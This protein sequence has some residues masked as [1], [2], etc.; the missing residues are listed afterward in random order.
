MK[1]FSN[2]RS[3]LQSQRIFTQYQ[4]ARGFKRPKDPSNILIRL[5][6]QGHSTILNRLL[7]GLGRQLSGL[8]IEQ[9]S[10]II[11]LSQ[12]RGITIRI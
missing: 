2:L 6:A 8:V 10:P 7:M 5:D 4:K 9:I 3:T 12:S 11:I 1:E